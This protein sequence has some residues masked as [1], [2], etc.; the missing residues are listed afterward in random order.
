MPINALAALVSITI[1]SRL[2]GGDL[3]SHFQETFFFLSNLFYFCASQ[4]KAWKIV[5]YYN[6]TKQKLS[7]IIGIGRK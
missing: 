2:E 7:E 6:Q 1:S 3:S 5:S 4:L